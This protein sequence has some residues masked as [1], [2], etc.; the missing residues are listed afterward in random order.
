M[1]P[2]T[3]T[4]TEQAGKRGVKYNQ[5][6]DI[7]SL[8]IILFYL[9]YNRTPF[10]D[11]NKGIKIVSIKEGDILYPACDNVEA[12]DLLKVSL[13]FQIFPLLLQF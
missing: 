2:E 3:V 11:F 9:V 12:V 5:K 4:K 1:A 13:R 8:G 7:W 10:E 6:A